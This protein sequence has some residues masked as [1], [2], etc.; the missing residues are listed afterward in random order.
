MIVLL[1]VW[2]PLTSSKNLTYFVLSMSRQAA[3]LRD[4]QAR[5]RCGHLD[6]LHGY[7]LPRRRVL[8]PFP[9]LQ[10]PR[11]RP[12][13]RCIRPRRGSSSDCPD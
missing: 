5:C 8:D 1:C 10:A 9:H 11:R 7:R 3:V 4:L 13:R 12:R 2:S 6:H